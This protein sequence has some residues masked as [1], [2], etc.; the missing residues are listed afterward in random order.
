[1]DQMGMPSAGDMAKI[2]E[3][4]TGFVETIR[5]LFPGITVKSL[6]RGESYTARKILDDCELI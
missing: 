4:T 5:R 3:A 2:G 1:M 6:Q